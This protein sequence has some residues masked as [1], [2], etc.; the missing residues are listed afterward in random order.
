[1]TVRRGAP[2]APVIQAGVVDR[3]KR[4]SFLEGVRGVAAMIVVLQHVLADQFPAYRDWT[5]DYLDLGRV[6]VV[7]FFL[8]SGYVIPLS[9]AG[10]TV[11]T[12]AV[13]RFFRL[14][15]VYWL[16]LAFYLLVSLAGPGLPDPVSPLGMV[17]NVLMLHGVLGI[18]SLL[19]PAW[20]LSIEL[21][22]YVQSALA[23][24]RG[25]LDKS[26]HIGWA[27]L[28]LYLL[29][30]AGE[31]VT[32]SDLPTTLPM[33]LLVASIGHA[34]HLRDTSGGGAWQPLAVAG[35]VLVPLG[36][37]LG[38]DGDGEWPPFRYS[39]SFIA[40]LVLFGAFYV[41]R[42]HAVARPLIFLG[43]ISYA[44]YLFHPVT[45]V[46][47]RD[48][49]GLA[50]VAANLVVSTAVAYLVHRYVEKPSIDTGRRLTAARRQPTKAQ[51]ADE[52]AA[53]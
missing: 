14:Y 47:F 34:L 1:M 23:K 24:S 19:P 32:G 28:A 10:Q 5:A 41:A 9:L 12:F 46:V 22:F 27:W 53:P 42:R 40:G 17:L 33:L 39:A 36:A 49:S 13:R 30:C 11:G 45:M 51:A 7:A 31:R 50:Y 29:M 18:V 43:G 8:V 3:S 35:A 21:I 15:P 2:A 38:V 20:T 26:V 44:L 48:M 37:Y 25:L 52:Q 16:A 4:I 6:G